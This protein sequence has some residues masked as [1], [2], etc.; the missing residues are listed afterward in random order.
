MRIR[1]NGLNIG[2]IPLFRLEQDGY[3][4]FLCDLSVSVVGNSIKYTPLYRPIL[5]IQRGDGYLWLSIND[6]QIYLSR[7][8]INVW[9]NSMQRGPRG[10]DETGMS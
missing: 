1:V 7:G 10:D 2:S 6:H 3:F 5:K 8:K 9:K 4:A